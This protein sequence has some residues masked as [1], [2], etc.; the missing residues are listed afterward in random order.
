[1]AY[2]IFDLDGTVICSKHRYR[3]LP[4]GMID[5]QYWFDMATPENVAKDSLL[6]L[7]GSMKR[8]YDRH[9]IIVCTARTMK[10]ADWKYLSDNGL[11]FHDALFRVEGDMRGDG[12]M[13]T[14]LLTNYF[15]ERNTTA[16]AENVIMFDDNVKVIAAMREMKIHCFD[17]NEMNRKM[18]A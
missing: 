16:A 2:V 6:P 4:C 8:L 5:L 7:A 14:S 3:D 1:M 13:K 17:A 9:T 18:A 15:A 12:D 11:K 10:E